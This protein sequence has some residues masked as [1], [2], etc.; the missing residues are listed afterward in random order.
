MGC[1][2]KDLDLGLIDFPASIDSEEV[3]LCWK[4]GEPAVP[5]G[6]ASTRAS[7]PADRSKA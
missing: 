4:A 6:T 3:Y 5:T 1:L 2:V 7:R